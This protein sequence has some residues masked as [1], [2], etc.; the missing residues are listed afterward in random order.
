MKRSKQHWQLSFYSF[1]MDLEDMVDHNCELYQLALHTDWDLIDYLYSMHFSSNTGP[2]PYSSRYAYGAVY[3]Q[4]KFGMTDREFVD[5]LKHDAAVQ[6]FLGCTNY[7]P[8]KN[9]CDPSSL[10]IFRKRFTNEM[11]NVINDHAHSPKERSQSD[12]FLS[13][14]EYALVRASIQS[15]SD[16]SDSSDDNSNDASEDGSHPVLPGFESEEEFSALCDQALPA[17]SA[18]AAEP[19]S[20]EPVQTTD[21]D[22]SR[23]QTKKKSDKR[24][25]KSD[26][27]VKKAVISKSVLISGAV[28]LLRQGTVLLDATCCPVD[29]KFP[30]DLRLLH[31]SRLWTEGIIDVFYDI[32]GPLSGN[33]KPRT[34]RKKANKDYKSFSRDPKNQNSDKIRDHIELQ[35]VC[36]NRNL[37]YIDAYL[38][39]EP[40]LINQLTNVQRDR[41]ST[42]RE[43]YI[44][45]KTMFEKDERRINDRIISLAQPWIRPIVRGKVKNRTE[46]GPKLAIS[47]LDGKVFQDIL[48]FDAF[49]E[50]SSDNLIKAIEAYIRRTGHLPEKIDADKI[51]CS[52]ENRQICKVLGIQLSAPR[53][54][55]KPKNKDETDRQLE[56]DQAERNTVECR[57]GNMKRKDGL[58][59]IFAKLRNT[60]L[61]QIAMALLIRNDRT[62]Y[63]NGLA[64]A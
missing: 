55:R 41:L 50:G 17:E 63:L 15:A 4:Q 46:F 26:E 23:K 57:F 43:L 52:R 32:A 56:R 33:K 20:S 38:D 7:D 21:E 34:Y 13:D 53:L 39:R 29:I 12:P 42:L 48:E 8:V 28:D 10:T 18:Q 11:I 58:S 36:L 3:L 49:N 45:Q 14:E 19:A 60:Q 1:N 61:S 62:D 59:L 22:S 44:Q 6:F 37:K 64:A 35:L 25:K 24:R 30:T 47:V 31:E 40:D 9:T 16:Q 2:L 5:R 51:Y 54:G 27:D